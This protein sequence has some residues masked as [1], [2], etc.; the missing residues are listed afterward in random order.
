MDSAV[1][2]AC[3]GMGLALAV[4]VV[5]G[6][7]GREGSLGLALEIVAA[8]AGALLFAAS[9]SANDHTSWPGYFIGAL[10][11]LG[12]YLVARDVAVGAAGR[13]SS[14]SPAAIA[15]FMVLFAL[16][17]A[18]L[19]LLWGP[20][21]LA[22]LVLVAVIAVGQRRRATRKHEGLRVLR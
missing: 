11:A 13:A 12:A 1:V 10:V 17:L 21:A 4:G 9:L 18:G 22:G 7:L 5:A 16:A 20:I 15:G 3:Q 2:S 6:A 19:S 14:G 8:V